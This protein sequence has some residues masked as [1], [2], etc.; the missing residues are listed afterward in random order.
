MKEQIKRKNNVV[1]IR[2][3]SGYLPHVNGKIMCKVV[4]TGNGYAAR[5]NSFS[6]STDDHY[7]HLDYSEAALMLKALVAFAPELEAGD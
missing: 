1:T 7:V 3:Q 2:A 4:N 6:S 5:F